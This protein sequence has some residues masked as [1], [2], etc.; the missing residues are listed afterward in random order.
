[1]S[2]SVRFTVETSGVWLLVGVGLILLI[3]AGL[4]YVFRTYGR[5]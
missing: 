4:F 2:R 1:M 5:R 3:G